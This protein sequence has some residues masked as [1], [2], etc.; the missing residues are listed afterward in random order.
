MA[1]ITSNN[2]F[3]STSGTIFTGT[4]APAGTLFTTTVTSNFPY[5]PPSKAEPMKPIVL[6]KLPVTNLDPRSTTFLDRFSD[7]EIGLGNAAS[8]RADTLTSELN[9]M[10]V[11]A[12]SEKS[13]LFTVRN[14]TKILNMT[15]FEKG[16]DFFVGVR[17]ESHNSALKDDAF[18]TNFAKIID[19]TLSRDFPV[20]GLNVG[21]RSLY[22]DEYQVDLVNKAYLPGDDGVVY[23]VFVRFKYSGPSSASV[24]RSNSVAKKKGFLVNIWSLTSYIS[25]AAHPESLNAYESAGVPHDLV[26]HCMKYVGLDIKSDGCMSLSIIVNGKTHTKALPRHLQ[27]YLINALNY[28]N[29]CPRGACVALSTTH[30]NMVYFSYNCREAF[31]IDGSYAYIGG[32]EFK[33]ANPNLR[34]YIDFL[35]GTTGVYY[36]KFNQFTVN[37]FVKSFSSLLFDS[38]SGN[39]VGNFI[40]EW[41]SEINYAAGLDSISKQWPDV[42]TKD[43]VN[44]LNYEKYAY[45]TPIAQAIGVV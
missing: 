36:R 33:N 29:L 40:K 14:S 4:S 42:D 6:K 38:G 1:T 31:G 12:L 34:D 26:S 35:T 5:G 44:T 17:P 16:M 19:Q 30:A 22:R 15:Y 7:P 28:G 41:I 24:F 43:I 10:I 45:R 13:S 3:N 20:G 21:D 9:R 32:E 2:L 37:N 18:V 39:M 27:A 23:T 25:G 11:G 8:T